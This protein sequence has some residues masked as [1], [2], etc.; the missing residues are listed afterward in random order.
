MAGVH[1]NMRTGIKESQQDV[2]TTDQKDI[3]RHLEHWETQ[4]RYKRKNRRIHIFPKL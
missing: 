3:A 4:D 2:K 1:Y